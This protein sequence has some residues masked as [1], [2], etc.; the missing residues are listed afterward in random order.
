MTPHKQ[1][2]RHE[3]ASGIFGDCW[4]TAIACILDLHPTEVPHI[5]D[6]ELPSAEFNRRTNEYLATQGMIKI[7]WAHPCGEAHEESLR[8]LFNN[9]LIINP[10]IYYILSGRSRTGCNH[11]VVALGDK[12]VHDPSLDDAGIVGPCDDGF[13]W[14]TWFDALRAARPA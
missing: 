5:S 9:M 3:P 4:R 12:I 6:R 10:G 8:I 13:Y 1:M 11:A 2:F 7:E 14:I